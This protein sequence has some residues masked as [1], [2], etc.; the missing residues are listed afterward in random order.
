[1]ATIKS[2]LEKIKERMANAA[3]RAGRDP[4]TISLV[5]VSKKVSIDKIKEAIEAGHRLFGE[6]YVQEAREKIIE[7]GDEAQ[8][9]YIG[10]LQSNKAKTAASLF[11]VIETVDRIKLASALDNSLEKL[12]KTLSVF[13]QVNIGHEPQKSGVLPEDMERMLEDVNNRFRFIK[14]KGLMAMPP[15]FENPEAVRPYFRQMR[16]LYENLQEKGLLGLHGPA[17]L[18]MGMSGDFET[19]IEEGATL[20][21]VGT[22]LFGA[23]EL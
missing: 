5:A 16:N 6:N 8:W 23:R 13:I 7:L 10:H 2:N 22:A 19:A 21:R 18:S 4:D 1:M 3:R 17:E 20:V 11:H 15:Y 12:N 14:V 9:H